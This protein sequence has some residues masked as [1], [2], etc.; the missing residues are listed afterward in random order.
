MI[1]KNAKLRHLL[2]KHAK[3][4]LILLVEQKISFSILCDISKTDFN[5]PLP[6]DIAKGLNDLTLFILAD[7][8][9]ES[10]DFGVSGI[11]F[12]A[13]F[14]EQNFGS[15]VSIE[16]EGIVQILLQDEQLLKEISLF[17]NVANAQLYSDFDS[18]QEDFRDLDFSMQMLSSNPEN[19]Y[20]FS[21]KKGDKNE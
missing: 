16:Y 2:T 21:K 14:G 12:E 8:T 10:I 17:V 3:E 5:P 13:G 4:F 11:S 7:Y 20:L 15:L 19:S 1:I 6:E 18:I 9:F